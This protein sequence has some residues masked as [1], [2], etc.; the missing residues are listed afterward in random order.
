MMAFAAETIQDQP[1]DRGKR[2]TKK[3][4][5]KKKSITKQIEQNN[6]SSSDEAESGDDE[7]PQV[8]HSAIFLEKFT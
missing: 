3:K 7:D 5:L 6:G 4:V 8:T 1:E 2:L